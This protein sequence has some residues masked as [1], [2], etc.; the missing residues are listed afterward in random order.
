MCSS[1]TYACKGVFNPNIP[2]FASNS[3]EGFHFSPFHY[4]RACKI[5]NE[6][7]ATPYA[8][9]SARPKLYSNRIGTNEGFKRQRV[10]RPVKVVIGTVPTRSKWLAGMQGLYI[11]TEA[12][13]EVYILCNDILGVFSLIGCFFM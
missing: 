11:V 1:N 8:V 9:G 5:T 2:I 4:Y 13:A 3:T 6:H 10:G 7:C 12:S